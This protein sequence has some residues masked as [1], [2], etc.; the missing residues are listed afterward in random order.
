MCRLAAYIGPPR[1]LHELWLAPPH[2]LIVQSYAPREMRGAILNADGFGMAWYTDRVESPALYRSVLPLWSDENVAR[3]APHLVSGC[4]LANVRSATPGMGVQTTN[5]SPFVRGRWSFTHNGLVRSWKSLARKV[6]AALDDEQYAAI[7][8]ST[9]SEHVF[10]LVMTHLARDERDPIGAVR[11]ATRELEQLAAGALL[12]FVLTDGR[13]LIAVRHA[14]GSAASDGMPTPAEARS[15]GVG[16][17]SPSRSGATH[18]IGD[19]AP[20]L[21]RRAREGGVELASERLDEHG[22]ESVDPGTMLI[23]T[24]ERDT[25]IEA[26]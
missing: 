17:G 12:N 24:P 1:S 21:Y 11:G 6:R 3:M 13:W 4:A 22:W 10:A 23:V 14:I 9:D 5:V 18:V 19:A 2:N 8:G 20:S 7:E 15:A 16:V 25:R 26:L